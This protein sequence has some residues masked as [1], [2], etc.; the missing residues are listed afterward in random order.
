MSTDLTDEIFDPLISNY[1]RRQELIKKK[2]QNGED[3]FQMACKNW[4][5]KAL[6]DLLWYAVWNES[7]YPNEKQAKIQGARK[8]RMGV[9]S[10]VCD[11][12]IIMP[13]GMAAGV[14]L[15]WGNGKPSDSQKA[16]GEAMQRRGCRHAFVWTGKQLEETLRS[17][18]LEPR[19]PFP[20]I[21]QGSA[22]LLRQSIA[23]EE[24]WKR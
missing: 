2:R 21:N 7:Y 4:L 9:K 10:G 11:L 17:W 24:L 19:Y 20:P 1:N 15:K 16:W 23:A 13:N 18:G 22:K 8:K 6:P 5:E 3:I 14:E 12:M